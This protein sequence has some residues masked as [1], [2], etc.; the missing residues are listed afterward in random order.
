MRTLAKL[1]AVY[2]VCEQSDV[3]RARNIF[4]GILNDDQGFLNA[5][6]LSFF[7]CAP[8]F[9]SPFT[10]EGPTMT[11]LMTAAGVVVVDIVLAF[12]II[13]T[14]CGRRDRQR[15]VQDIRRGRDD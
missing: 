3:K 4:T 12:A 7:Q 9:L 1:H 2:R 15:T 10:S 14:R 8:F 5:V 13:C 11:L 6:P